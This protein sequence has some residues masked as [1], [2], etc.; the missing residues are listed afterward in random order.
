[1]LLS[2]SAVPG[3][4]C[5]PHA[6]LPPCK[7]Y[8]TN[9]FLNTPGPCYADPMRPARICRDCHVP[10]VLSDFAIGNRICK[11]CRK[12]RAHEWYERTKNFTDAELPDL[13]SLVEPPEPQADLQNPQ[14]RE[15]VLRNEETD[16]KQ[17]PVTAEDG[18]TL[19][20]LTKQVG[21]GTMK[22]AAGGQGGGLP[23]NGVEK[24]SEGGNLGAPLPSNA[25]QVR[26]IDEE[27]EES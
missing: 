9:R 19:E 16:P 26:F 7:R 27:E 20:N 8:A 23:S 4:S 24:P 13:P 18:E 10:K 14:T 15:K 11:A 2:S 3:L 5:N 12:V 17:S 6:N 1:V 25:P 21:D 22:G